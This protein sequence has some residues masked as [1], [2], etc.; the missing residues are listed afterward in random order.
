MCFDGL[1]GFNRLG[2]TR[3]CKEVH[4]YICVYTCMHVYITIHI[5][6]SIHIYI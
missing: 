1:T 6:T 4:T 2:D 5:Y 3:R